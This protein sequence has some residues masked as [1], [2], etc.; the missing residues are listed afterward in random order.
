MSKLVRLTS[1][2]DPDTIEAARVLLAELPRGRAI[3]AIAREILQKRHVRIVQLIGAEIELHRLAFLV[4]T[5][6]TTA[7]PSR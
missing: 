1:I 3:A 5:R 4:P 7:A 6:S 2:M